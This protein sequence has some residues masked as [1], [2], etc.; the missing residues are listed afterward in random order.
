MFVKSA[1][2][3]RAYARDGSMD[4]KIYSVSLTS[5]QSTRAAVSNVGTH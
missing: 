3:L 4:A 2:K 1:I 5:D